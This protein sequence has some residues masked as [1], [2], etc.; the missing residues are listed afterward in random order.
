M[1]NVPW[2]KKLKLCRENENCAKVNTLDTNQL[3]TMSCSR[4]K[5]KKIFLSEVYGQELI[6]VQ[7]ESQSE[8][9]EGQVR[10]VV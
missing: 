3:D 2:Q 4:Y 6:V 7:N 10:G 8:I 9:D 5:K 1:R